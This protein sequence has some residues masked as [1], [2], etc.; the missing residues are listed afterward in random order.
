M[1][2][3][4]VKL[5]LL[6]PVL[7]VGAVLAAKLGQPQE[8]PDI[9]QP[10][11]AYLESL[12]KKDPDAVAQI[13]RDRYQARLDAQRAQLLEQVRGG[14]L[15]PFELMGSAVVMGDSR[16]VGFWYYGFMEEG[17]TLTGAGHT[18]LDITAQ[19]DTLEAMNPQYIYL[20]YGLNDLKIGFW[21][22]M[23]RFLEAYAE[24]LE[25]IRT[26][27]PDAVIVVS[28]ILP[29]RESVYRDAAEALVD[30]DAKLD[31]DQRIEL[32]GLER[33]G[34]VPEWNKAL[35]QVCEEH[36]IIFVDNT[37]I[38]QEYAKLLEPDG[39]HMKKGFYPVWAR[40]LVIAALEEGDNLT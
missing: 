14:T 35:K 8:A 38:S 27:I 36:H 24:A 26:R 3:K 17:H 25:Q 31:Q 7:L 28:S 32:R 33:L 4:P 15:D 22:S 10:G 11:I 1:T 37:R 19:M 39:I 2:I 40:S 30:P 13:L 23:D 6:L 5:L 18:V 20:C 34:L 12:E 16:A 9:T 29:V 21:G